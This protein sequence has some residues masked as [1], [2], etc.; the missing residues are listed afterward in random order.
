MKSAI[1]HEAGQA[2]QV[3]PKEQ[4]DGKIISYELRAMSDEKQQT[5]NLKLHREKLNSLKN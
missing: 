3:M 4:N 1:P 5:T 2:Q